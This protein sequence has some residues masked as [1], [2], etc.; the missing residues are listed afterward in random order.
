MTKLVDVTVD[1][2]EATKGLTVAQKQVR[3]ATAGAL[4]DMAYEGRARVQGQMQKKFDR[5]TK[6]ALSAIRVFGKAKP[7]E[8]YVELGL[9]QGVGKNI[10]SGGSSERSLAH[11]FNGGTRAFKR[12]EAALMNLQYLAPGE[13]VVVPKDASWA[14]KIDQYGNLKPSFIVQLISYFQ[15]FSEQGYK[16][17]MTAEKKG[18]LAKIGK[19]KDGY[20]T[21]NGVVYFVVP[22][23]SKRGIFPRLINGRFDPHLPPGIWAKRLVHGVDVA[24]VVLFVKRAQ[25]KQRFDL[26]EIVSEAVREKFKS[27][28]DRRLEYALRT[29][30]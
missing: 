10:S 6:F 8:M 11:H 28:F 14:A 12:F 24:P 7:A 20:K 27:A 4:N 30:K 25:Y 22:S 23:V 5:P 18:K 26:K 17:N 3:F 16:A 19:T 15:G 2:K 9:S 1:I 21:I 13:N 29:A